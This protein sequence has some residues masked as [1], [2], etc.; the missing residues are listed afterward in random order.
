MKSNILSRDLDILLVGD[1]KQ[2]QKRGPIE[3]GGVKQKK[4]YKLDDI[5]W[6]DVLVHQDY[7]LGIY[8]GLEIVGGKNSGEENIK[9][10]YPGGSSVYVPI[11]KFDRIHKYIGIGGAEPKLTQIGTGAWEK[12][13][14]TT[15]KSVEK[16]VDYLIQNYMNKQKPRGFE[17]SGDKELIKRVVD[18]F[19][20]KETPDQSKACLLYTSDAAD[21]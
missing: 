1:G 14:L 12:Q 4:V 15:K 2:P 10:E 3:I 11:N 6:G 17:Y 7:G 13:K 19:P 21:E 20:Y 9:I 16:V 8:R 5:H 18:G